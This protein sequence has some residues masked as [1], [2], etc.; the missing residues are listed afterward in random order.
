MRIL[1]VIPTVSSF[2]AF[3]TELGA[4][5]VDGGHEVHLVADAPLPGVRPPL[6]SGIIQHPIRFPRGLNVLSHLMAARRL[7]A[8]VTAIQP[9]L[10]HAHFSAAIFTTAISFRRL[11]RGVRRPIVIGTYQGMISA[12]ARGVKKSMFQFAEAFSLRRLDASW[13]LTRD[14]LAHARRIAPG[15]DVRLQESKGFGCRTDLFNRTVIDAVQ[16]EAQKRQLGITGNPFTLV[17]AGRFVAFKGF[18]LTVHAFFKLHEQYPDTRLILAG[19]P[20][21]LHPTGLTP[22]EEAR[23]RGC[24]DIVRPGFVADMQSLLAVSD[25]MVFPSQ[26]E[27]MPVCIMEALAMQVPVITLNSRGCR[28]LVQDG[29]NGVIL[30]DERVETLVR[31]LKE[32]YAEFSAGGPRRFSLPPRPELDRMHYVWEQIG[33][34]RDCLTKMREREKE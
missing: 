5:L 20:D 13:V 10:I 24:R 32:L 3:L 1:F 25:V 16:I 8:L 34:Y 31:V 18:A 4:E 26:R 9:D 15:T 27:G 29:V 2:Q 11:P 22:Q 33:V 30:P 6:P 19:N 28:D 23:M 21:V 12:L 17:F 7:T 14:D